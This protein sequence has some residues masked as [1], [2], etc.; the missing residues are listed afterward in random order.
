MDVREMQHLSYVA[1]SSWLASFFMS[2]TDSVF[3]EKHAM[4][5]AVVCLIDEEQ[6]GAIGEMV[7]TRLSRAYYYT[8][9]GF[10]VGLG[11]SSLRSIYMS[12]LSA[13]ERAEQWKKHHVYMMDNSPYNE[14]MAQEL[15]RI[16]AFRKTQKE[17][18][19]QLLRAKIDGH[20]AKIAD[21]NQRVT[22]LHTQLKETGDHP[23][24]KDHQA[25][26]KAIED[27]VIRLKEANQLSE[28]FPRRSGEN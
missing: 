19:K 21:V 2:V 18:R 8:G 12:N 1:S 22:K 14:N 28:A 6:H 3:G 23:S 10:T 24:W 4:K 20:M 15:E 16:S 7:I 9:G 26:K 13:Q 11:S 17:A 5:Q 25:L 27:D